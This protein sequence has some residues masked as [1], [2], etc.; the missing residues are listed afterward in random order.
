MLYSGLN[1]KV[2]IGLVPIRRDVT[3]RP[4]IFNWEKAEERGV[5]CVKYIIDNF[6][7][8]N[9]SFVDLKGVNDVEVMYCENDVDKALEKFKAEK[10]DAVV[11]IN[12]NFGNEEAAGRFAKEMD[13]PVLLWGPIDDVFEPDGTRYTDTQ[14]GLF[15]TSRQFQRLGVKFS[16]I[17]NC[18][19][20]DEAFTDG[21]KKFIAVA[22][23]VKNFRGMRI[24]QVGCRPK[25]FCSVMINE[26][27]LLAKFGV[28]IVPVNMATVIDKFNRIMKEN[29][30]EIKKG[31]DIIRAR[32]EIDEIVEKDAEKM[33]ALVL[34]YKEIFEET[35]V[36]AISSECWTSMPLGVG[37]VPCTAFSFLADMGYIV[38]C[39]SDIYGAI[40]MSMLA[41]ATLGEKTPFF[42][43]FTVRHPENKNAELLWHC[44]PFAYSLKAEDSVAKNINQRPW[45]RVKDG[46][47]TVC[48]MDQDNGDYTFLNGT[49][50]ATDGPYTFGT[51]LWAQFDDLNKWERRLVEG[52]YI[53]HMA[54]IEGD[55]T[56][57]IREFCKYA[58]DITPDNV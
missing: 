19:I 43:E 53:H 38:A 44:G 58:G 22:C 32:Y 26:H 8:E 15:G 50:T 1:Y 42:G 37:V 40:A 47:Y 28:Q 16:Y 34:V 49:C 18:K 3:P 2:K 17:E 48:R 56:D 57:H 35:K 27:E 9:V 4:G 13:R 24:A 12:S 54:E 33:Y 46:K 5:A 52:P 39:E 11:I 45:F 31:A 23:M 25:P 14:C 55:Y 10:V 21:L 20:T 51:Y 7:T 41:C 29:V 36:Q 30:D 6:T